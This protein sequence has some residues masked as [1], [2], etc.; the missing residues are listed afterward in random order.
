MLFD[1]NT[2]TDKKSRASNRL[3]PVSILTGYIGKFT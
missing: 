3:K 2:F 1:K